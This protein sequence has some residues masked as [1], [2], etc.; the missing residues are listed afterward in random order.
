MLLLPLSTIKLR[1]RKKPNCRRKRNG[2]NPKLS[3]WI[4]NVEVGKNGKPV[5]EMLPSKNERRKF[6]KLKV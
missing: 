3:N 2:K 1:L 4:P 6:L 5:L